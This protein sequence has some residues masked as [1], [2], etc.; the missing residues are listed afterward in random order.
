D[1]LLALLVERRQLFESDADSMR[2]DVKGLLR[3]NIPFFIQPTW[4]ITGEGE[5]Q[6]GNEIAHKFAQCLLTA[7]AGQQ[8]PTILWGMGQLVEIKQFGTVYQLNDTGFVATADH[9]D[10]PRRTRYWLDKHHRK[11]DFSLARLAMQT[12][13]AGLPSEPQMATWATLAWLQ[14]KQP[15]TLANILLELA[16]LQASG[17]PRRRATVYRGDDEETL[18]LLRQRFDTLD[19]EDLIEWLDAL[20]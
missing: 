13:Q 9:F 20:D 1:A 14:D 2:M 17:D 18:A 16:D 10:W 4:D 12:S 19:V 15:A 6:L 8:P 11:R 7:R 3:R 5:F